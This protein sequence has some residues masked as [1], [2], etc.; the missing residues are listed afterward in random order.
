[1]LGARGKSDHGETGQKTKAVVQARDDSGLLWRWS[2]TEVLTL[3]LCFGDRTI[4]RSTDH[5]CENGFKIK[6]TLF[7]RNL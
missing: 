7:L 1:M 6:N 3:R 5:C 2:V 4:I